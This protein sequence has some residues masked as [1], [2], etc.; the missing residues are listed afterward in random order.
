MKKNVPGYPYGSGVPLLIEKAIKD[1]VAKAIK[2]YSEL[3]VV[4][5][6]DFSTHYASAKVGT[7]YLYSTDTSPT[8]A[9]KSVQ[10]YLTNY[11]YTD[12]DGSQLFIGADESTYLR[13]K[14]S[15]SWSA[16]EVISTTSASN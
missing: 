3:E 11:K 16:W 4:S 13:Y 12:A 6:L 1:T 10:G 15:D 9:P 5:T 7:T 14:T 8:N 2:E